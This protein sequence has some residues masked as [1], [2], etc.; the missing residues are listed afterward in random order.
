VRKDVVLNW[1]DGSARDGY[2]AVKECRSV[3]VERPSCSTSGGH[4]DGA[5]E[6]AGRDEARVEEDEVE[7]GDAAVSFLVMDAQE[8]N[9]VQE[10]QGLPS[11]PRTTPFGSFLGG[12][13]VP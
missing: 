4:S 6:S 13:A 2:V 7:E 5:S 8:A 9:D 1:R 3:Q 10:R 11:L 12:S